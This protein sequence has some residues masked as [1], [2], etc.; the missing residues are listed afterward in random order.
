MLAMIY[1]QPSFRERMDMRYT[2][3]R[4]EPL[5]ILLAA[6]R[7]KMEKIALEIKDKGLRGNVLNFVIE[8]G[9]CE[10][11]VK[12]NIESLLQVFPVCELAPLAKIEQDAYQITCPFECARLYEKKI[13]KAFRIILN[14]YKVIREVREIMRTQLNEILYAFLKIRML[15]K[16]SAKEL[17]AD[18]NLF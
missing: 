6:V 15:S 2:I 1:T 5:K 12:N 11:Q 13:V 10:E 7:L 4:L 3:A 16:F 17:K 8:T 9:P 18:T 14:D